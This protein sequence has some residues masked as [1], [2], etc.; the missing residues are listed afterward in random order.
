MSTFLVQIQL[1]FFIL[2]FLY[3]I[4]RNVNNAKYTSKDNVIEIIKLPIINLNDNL[5]M[6]LLKE[7]SKI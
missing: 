7:K 2:F 5:M 4:T 1:N 3:K 6:L